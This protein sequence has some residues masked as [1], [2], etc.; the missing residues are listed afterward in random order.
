MHDLDITSGSSE[1]I[2]GILINSELT[3]RDYITRLC[4]KVNQKHSALARGSKY[5]ALQK[6]HLLIISFF[7]SQFNYWTLV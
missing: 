6:R 3:F 4:S 5:M 7:I 2:L 1:E